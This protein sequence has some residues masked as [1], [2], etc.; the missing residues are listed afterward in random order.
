MRSNYVVM[1]LAVGLLVACG[2][3]K[4]RDTP[5]P[6]APSPS[7]AAADPCAADTQPRPSTRE[8]EQDVE[9]ALHKAGVAVGKGLEAAGRALEHAG[10]AVASHAQSQPDTAEPD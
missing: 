4:K 7:I 6:P 10:Q 3:K 5:M 9:A 2:C 1:L 8:V